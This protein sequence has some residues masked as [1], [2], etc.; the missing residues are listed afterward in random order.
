MIGPLLR[1]AASSVAARS[2]RTAVEDAL[3]RT[4][5]SIGA[6]LAVVVAAVCLSCS[7]YIL[8]ERQLDSAAASAI[9][10]AF[11]GIVGAGYFVAARRRRN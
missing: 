2:M 6:A 11:W 7:A 5:L 8:I 4:L 1:V 10:G 9:V 3:T